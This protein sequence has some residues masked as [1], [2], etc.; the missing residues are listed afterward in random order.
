MDDRSQRQKFI[1][2]ARELGCEDDE[3]AFAEKLRK[4]AKGSVKNRESDKS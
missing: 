1:D 3:K 4:V 2:T